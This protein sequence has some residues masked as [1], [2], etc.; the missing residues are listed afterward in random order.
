MLETHQH[1]LIHKVDTGDIIHSFIR[2]ILGDIIHSFIRL[3]LETHISILSFIRLRLGDFI[4]SFIRL[5]LGRHCSFT[6]SSVP[7]VEHRQTL[8]V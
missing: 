3:I 6:R 5:I 1:S 4:H 7:S 2:L 8:L